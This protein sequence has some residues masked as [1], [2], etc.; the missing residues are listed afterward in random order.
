MLTTGKSVGNT[1]AGIMLFSINYCRINFYVSHISKNLCY[2]KYDTMNL[3]MQ[4]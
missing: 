4:K 2:V 1:H 3:E